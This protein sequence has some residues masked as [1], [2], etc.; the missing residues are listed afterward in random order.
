ML[1]ND[2]MANIAHQ[3]RPKP[4]DD[5][6][7]ESRPALLT[8]PSFTR[9]YSSW[10]AQEDDLLTE[11]KA[12]LD[13]DSKNEGEY[14]RLVRKGYQLYSEAVHAKIR[15]SH[16]D[17]AYMAT[18]AWKT[19]FEAGLMWMGGWRPSSAIVLA[20]SLMG[21]EMESEL[22]RL[23]EGVSL[24]SMAALSAKQLAR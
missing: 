5:E 20:Y 22:Q 13:S 12:A 17:V 11:L 18:G 10:L 2:L 16:E 24:P 15:A 14:A 1:P 3:A 9:F 6:E 23:L 4:M 8:I 7:A 21:L 19:P